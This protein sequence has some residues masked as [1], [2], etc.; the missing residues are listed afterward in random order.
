MVK[1]YF[2]LASI[3]LL[4]LI[5]C[6]KNT[7]MKDSNV[8]TTL[9]LNLKEGSY[10]IIREKSELKWTGKEFSSKT[11]TGTL[12]LKEGRININSNGMIEGKVVI[13]ERKEKQIEHAKTLSK[14]AVL[15]KLGDKISNVTDVINNPPSKWDINRRKVYLDWAEKVISNCPQVNEKMESKFQEVLSAGRESLI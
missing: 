8:S 7:G 12:F 15:I 10:N 9:H 14:G 5:G 2:S 6:S 13:D 1:R 11:H 3:I 4:F